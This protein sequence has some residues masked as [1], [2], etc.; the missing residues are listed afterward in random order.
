[1]KKKIYFI[2]TVYDP[3]HIFLGPYLSDLNKEYSITVICNLKKNSFPKINNYKY[4]NVNISRNPNLVSDMLTIII[5]FGFFIFKRPHKIISITPKAGFIS[6][7]LSRLLFI[8]NLHF[9]TGQVWE[10]K[11][12]I[13]VKTFFKLIDKFIGHFSHKIIVDSG[14]QYHTLLNHNLINKKAI[15]FNSVSGIDFKKFYKNV[16]YKNT[17]KKKFN[18]SNYSFGLIYVGR[19]NHDKGIINLLKIYKDLKKKLDKNIFMVIVGEDE[20][21]Y[22]KN[23]TNAFLKKNQIFYFNKSNNINYYLNICD[24]FITCSIREGFCQSI[25]E[26]NSI[27]LPAVANNLYNLKETIINKKTGYLLQNTNNFTK[28]ILSLYYDNALY[29]KLSNRCIRRCRNDFNQKTFFNK[30]RSFLFAND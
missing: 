16:N 1:M 26:A 12:N 28:A 22:F 14:P 4:L 19:I 18:L 13:F 29:Q 5:L 10:R 17:F 8:D 11:T 30:F 27:G 24:L 6:T 2:A 3:I 25:I 7:I 23:I 20:I 21:G 9:I 15:F